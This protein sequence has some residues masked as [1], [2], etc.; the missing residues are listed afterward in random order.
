MSDVIK[1]KNDK[2]NTNN[3]VDLQSASF[4]PTYKRNNKAEPII[5]QNPSDTSDG[6]LEIAQGDQIT[7]ENPQI[8]I[9]GVIDVGEFA[10]NAALHA[11]SGI[12]EINLGYLKA[13]WRV[14]TDSITYVQLWFG[15][16]KNKSWKDYSGTSDSIKVNI[17]SIDPVPMEDSDGLHLIKY[18]MSLKEVR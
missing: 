11:T 6:H 13:L 15:Q 5:G 12:T 17:D 2:L 18:T 8:T 7:I 3:W 14:R 1:I 16:D 10:D 9:S 4:K